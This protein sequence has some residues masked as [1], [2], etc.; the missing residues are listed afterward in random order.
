ME[1]HAALIV[2]AIANLLRNAARHAPGSRVSVE[3]RLLDE[4]VVILVEDDGPGVLPDDRESVFDRLSRGTRARQSGGGLGLGLPLT[5][6]VARRH[7]GDCW[8]EPGPGCRVR[9]RLPSS[10]APSAHTQ[11]P[12]GVGAG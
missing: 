6:E 4:S 2:S 9:M 3:A 7:G 12:G 10:D 11:R 1:V 8:M 5:R